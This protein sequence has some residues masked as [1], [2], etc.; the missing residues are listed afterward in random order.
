M[1]PQA[2]KPGVEVMPWNQ[3]SKSFH[4]SRLFPCQECD[5]VAKV[6]CK[7]LFK[8]VLAKRQIT[9]LTTLNNNEVPGLSPWHGGWKHGIYI[10]QQ[11]CTEC[12]LHTKCGALLWRIQKNSNAIS[13]VLLSIR[14]SCSWRD[15]VK[16]DKNIQK[17]QL[18]LH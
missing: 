6:I 15:T 9:S 2:E 14:L 10:N 7:I 18:V 8:F 16:S 17:C 4:F 11:Q 5:G 12:F 1:G 13:M 3:F